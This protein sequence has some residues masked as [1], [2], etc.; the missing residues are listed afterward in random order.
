M[1]TATATNAPCGIEPFDKH[2]GIG[3]QVERGDL[4]P[5]VRVNRLR[6]VFLD[7]EFTIDSQ[8]A[9]LVTQ[10]YKEYANEPQQIKCARALENIL[11]NINIAIYDDELI[12][13]NGCAPFKAAPIYPEFSYKWIID[14]MENSPFDKREHDEYYMTDKVAEELKSIAEFWDGKTVSEEI[15]SNLSW[16]DK[17]GSNMGRGLYLLNLYHLGG[18]G[19]FV[20][21]YPMLMKLGFGGIKKLVEEKLAATADPEKKELYT[22][23]LIVLDASIAYGERYVALVSQMAEKET[24]PTR[25]AE[26]LQISANCAQVAAGVPQ[27]TWQALQLWHTATNIILMESNGH[28]VSYGRMDQWLYPFYQA[29]MDSGIVTKEF[30]QELLDTTYIKCGSTSK[31]RDKMTVISNAGRGWGGESLTIG[32]VKRDGTD[33]TNDLTFMMIDASIH[34]RLACPWLCVRVHENTPNELKIKY[35]EAIRAGFGHPKLYNDQAAVPAQLK[36]G[37]TIEEARDYAI[38]GCVEIDTPGE[39]YGWHDAAYMN[40]AKVFEM[41]INGGRCIS[42]SGDTCPMHPIC[43]GAGTHLGPDTGSLA[44]FKSFDELVESYDKQMEYWT[45][46]M[47]NGIEAMDLAHRKVKP[48]PYLSCLFN[49][50]I[51]TGVEINAGGAKYNHTGPQGAGVATVAD[52]MAVAKQ[53]IFDEKRVTGEQLLTAVNYNWQTFDELY[54][55]VNSDKVHHYGNNDDYADDCARIAFDTY[56]KHVENRTNCRGGSYTPGVYTVSANVGLGLIQAASIDGRTAQEPISD[57]MGPTHTVASAHDINGPTAMLTSVTK[58]DHTRATNGTL[59]N[60]KVSPECMSGETG[61]D[62]LIH[63]LDVY[64]DRKGMHSQV[65]VMSSAM[66]KDALVHPELYKDM[67]VRVAGYSAYFVE[68]SKPLQYD[69]IGRTEMSFE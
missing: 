34:T 37:R 12:V 48:L 45:D 64:F 62:N 5:Y 53:L 43:G 9:L 20:A 16:E 4:S 15:E 17:K 36:K 35:T 63:L 49:S 6:K 10:A 31:L 32:G 60:W 39:E 40:I 58:M 8:R 38:V 59:L 14:E 25:K 55:L 56:C 23:Q 29:D 69:L 66:M 57:N 67:L 11:R 28:S 27:T 33:A 18:V 52:G 50:C 21:D 2:Y 24:N 51:E 54:A 13:G 65:N 68:L 30:I 19:H 22:S 46:R 61:R 47:Y 42:C 41:A 7:T 44:T 1:S 26:L 3:Y